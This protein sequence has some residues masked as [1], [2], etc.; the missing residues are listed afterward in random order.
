MLGKRNLT[1]S[2]SNIGLVYKPNHSPN[3]D[4]NSENANPNQQ[5]LSPM[6]LDYINPKSNKL[7][8]YLLEDASSDSES[9]FEP[10][11]VNA[12]TSDF[13]N[14]SPRSESPRADEKSPRKRNFCT[15][16]D[17][18]KNGCLRSVLSRSLDC[19]SK[20]P[21]FCRGKRKNTGRGYF[22]GRPYRQPKSKKVQRSYSA[23][24]GDLNFLDNTPV[25]C[26]SPPLKRKRANT[27]SQVTRSG[28]YH[29]KT[30]TEILDVDV[31][32]VLLSDNNNNDT[33]RVIDCRFP[34]EYESGHIQRA[35]N[36]PTLDKVVR[37]FNYIDPTEGQNDED[38]IVFHCE[39]SCTRAP[40]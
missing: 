23:S 11:A 31:L 10:Y 9:S 2:S 4:F 37:I 30:S 15:Y 12:L 26:N 28:K 32:S 19:V 13:R 39:F 40:Q 33:L 8:N 22:G 1:R 6:E 5:P 18:N 34:P 25:V 27:F 24:T 38:I 17:S 21:D 20:A 36:I 29:K 35:I 16:E 14:L 3:M 7:S